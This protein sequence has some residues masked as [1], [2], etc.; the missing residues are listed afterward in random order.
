[1]SIYVTLVP[2]DTAPP[3]VG[4]GICSEQSIV[5]PDQP[6]FEGCELYGKSTSVTITKG[7]AATVRWVMRDRKGAPIDLSTCLEAD[8]P[9]TVKVQIRNALDECA[10]PVSVDGEDYDAGGGVV[11]FDV[12]SKVYKKPCLYILEIGIVNSDGNLIFSNT[13]ILSVEPG[14]FGDP[15]CCSPLTLGAIRTELRDSGLENEI[16]KDVEFDDA[17]I[18][19]AVLDVIR[20]W[21]EI[22]PDVARYSACGFPFKAYWLK[23]V[24]GRLL[25]TAAVWYERN[26]LQAA[27]GGLSLDDRNKLQSYAMLSKTYLDEWRTFVDRKKFEININGGFGIVG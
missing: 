13:A 14:L 20:E 15:S 7:Q 2:P 9:A 5:H 18:L 24:C 16:L 26:R 12:P 8:P 27:G 4:T 11:Q 19:H 25:R 1:M 22:P 3:G 21:N 10:R 23:G 6:T 17:E